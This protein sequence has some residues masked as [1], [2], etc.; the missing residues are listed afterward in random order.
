MSTF[1]SSIK[2]PRKQF[3]WSPWKK[4]DDF[5]DCKIQKWVLGKCTINTFNGYNFRLQG[6]VIRKE[7]LCTASLNY[8]YFFPS[9]KNDT[10]QWIRQVWQSCCRTV[11]S[12][13]PVWVYLPMILFYICH[14]WVPPHDP[15]AS[16]WAVG[17]LPDTSA[18]DLLS[19]S[20]FRFFSIQVCLQV[21]IFFFLQ[22]SYVWEFSNTHNQI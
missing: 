8:Y 9:L 11:Y 14:F 4:H 12:L 1:I 6:K 17:R 16:V 18:P 21:N 19:F 10:E 2:I 20:L 13:V 3:S 5:L 7:K 15:Y 22:A